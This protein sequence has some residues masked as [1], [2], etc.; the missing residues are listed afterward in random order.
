[1]SLEN[2]MKPIGPTYP[3]ALPNG[4]DAASI[5]TRI[6]K[7]KKMLDQGYLVFARDLWDVYERQLYLGWGY[8]TYDDY[9]KHEA[10]ISKGSAYRA[11]LIFQTFV[12][13]CNVRPDD[14][15]G[16]AQGRIHMLRPIVNPQNVRA[17]IQ[18]ARDL[19]WSDFN[20][21][22]DR[23]KLKFIQAKPTATTAPGTKSGPVT[24]IKGSNQSPRPSKP[25]KFKARTFRLP[26]DTD[27]LLDEA[28]ATAKRT[29][30]SH[31]D[32]FNLGMILQ[33]F[34]AHRLTQE[35]K[36]DGRLYYHLRH[37][38][39]IYGG[40]II[41]VKNEKAWEVLS[42]AIEDHP[43]ILKSTDKDIQKNDGT[44]STDSPDDVG[45]TGDS[46]EEANS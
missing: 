26:E 25:Q 36:K 22:V 21:E 1:M 5:R 43:D 37:M 18:Q 13:K 39:K 9:L 3:I 14:L 35:G 38:E 16:I 32:G 24:V 19:S 12:W 15:N 2:S 33:H 41:H 10:G 46:G 40:H 4:N 28:L 6:P 42:K 27:T 11:R 31:S 8:E 23:E 30:K 34:L 44:T 20:D 29:T 7:L 17:W 45:R